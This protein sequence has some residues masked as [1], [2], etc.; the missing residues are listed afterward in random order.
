M[1]MQKITAFLLV[2]ALFAAPS[3]MAGKYKRVHKNAVVIAMFGTTVEPALKSLLNIKQRMEARFPRTP[4]R[5]AFT[6]N[7][8]RKVWQKRAADPSYAKAHPGVPDEILHVKGPLAA[9][10]ELQDA[11]FDTIV[12][13]PTH[14]APGEEFLDLKNYVTAL[15]G[16]ETI[17]KKYKPFNKV[18]IGRPAFGAFGP[19]HPYPDDIRAV[20]R[21][22]APDAAAARKMG[23]ALLYMGHGNEFFPSGGS[24]LEFEAMMNRA[25]PETKTIVGCVEGFPSRDDAIARLQA[26]GIRKVLLKPLMVVAGDHATNDMAGPGPDSWL[27]VLKSKG[28]QVTPVKKGLGEND[29]FADIFVSHAADAARDAGIELK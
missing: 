28:F 14:L 3:A 20:V 18:V 26:L 22:L 25:Y 15:N 19:R 4:V 21:A 2:F 11:G 24:Y 6:S 17:K 5:M 10:A 27:S 12:V 9:M 1:K 23:A 16:I 7:I 29:A 8:I 13:Q